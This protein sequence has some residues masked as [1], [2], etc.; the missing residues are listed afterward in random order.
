M[1]PAKEPLSS[2]SDRAG[3]LEDPAWGTSV[4]VPPVAGWEHVKIAVHCCEE[5]LLSREA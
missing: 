5:A 4:V 2:N 3:A 1:C